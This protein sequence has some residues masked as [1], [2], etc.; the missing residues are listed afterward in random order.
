MGRCRGQRLRQSRL[1][2]SRHQRADHAADAAAFPR[3][4]DR[5][6]SARRRP[7]R[8]HQ[9]YRRQHRACDARADRRLR[10]STWARPHR[11]LL[12]DGGC[13]VRAEERIFR[14]RR[15]SERRRLQGDECDR[16]PG[17]RACPRPVRR[18]SGGVVAMIARPR[19]LAIDVMRGMT[20]ALMIVVNMSV[21]ASYA[22]L[23]HA[24]WNGL[25]PTDVVFP[26]FL[27]VAG[28][29][30]SFALEGYRRL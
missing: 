13:E 9:R 29:S 27:F 24:K 22:P 5:I 20:L 3:G 23:Q 7:P 19:S 11:L 8:R 25:T 17:D 16:A 26:T 4:R 6:A 30:M 12:A 2:Q 15:A 21:D 10:A 28:A 1:R 14:R 18:T